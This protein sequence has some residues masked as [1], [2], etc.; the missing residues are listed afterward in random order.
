VK[1]YY[2]ENGTT[3]FHGDCREILPSLPPVDLVLTDPPY[4]MNNNADY[5]R[6]S[7]GN[8]R[9]GNAVKHERILGDDT[10]FDPGFLLKVPSIIWG[11][12]HF[13]RHLPAGGC[14]IWIKRNDS[15]FG[16]FLS[17]AEIAF[18]S[19]RQGVFCYRQVFAGSQKALDAGFNAYAESAHPNQK[20][21]GLMKWCLGFAANA[22]S[23]LD[24]FMGSG[25]TLRAAKDLGREAI[26]I[27]IEER[28]CEIAANRLRQEVLQ[29]EATA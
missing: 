22:K 13:W 16:S 3:I 14:L 12:N 24:P 8:T 19:G 27:E 9:R 21:V 17:D 20:P 10:E 4:G 25:T 2:E 1:P 23:I 29:F 7:G 28:Y 5:T 18:I 11:A 26:G 6:F 15:A